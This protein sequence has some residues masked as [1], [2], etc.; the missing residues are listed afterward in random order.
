MRRSPKCSH[1]RAPKVSWGRYSGSEQIPT[2]GS[3][4]LATR[5]MACC[6]GFSSRE[7][8]QK[9]SG[10]ATTTR[11]L[12]GKCSETRLASIVRYRVLSHPV[13]S[14]IRVIA[15]GGRCD[16]DR[17]AGYPVSDS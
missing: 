13:D 7:P 16:A 9:V 10:S 1:N 4:L 3:S 14:F 11:P 8:S 5:I 12:L 15:I 17:I 6:T 2:D